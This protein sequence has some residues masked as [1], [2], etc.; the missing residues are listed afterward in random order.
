MARFDYLF[1][2]VTDRTVKNLLKKEDEY[3]KD[4]NRDQMWEKGVMDIDNPGKKEK[5]APS[6]VQ[7]KKRKARYN[8][9]SFI[10]LRWMGE[11]YKSLRVLFF[12][13][14]FIVSSDSTIWARFLEPQQRFEKAL[15]LTADS[16]E[17]LQKRLRDKIIIWL[18]A[19]R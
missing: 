10:T 15:G 17:E 18:R 2:K 9:T 1:P 11:F 8:K 7:Q 16:K 6:T 12:E 19:H 4:L 5:Y 3:I 13:K 14:Y